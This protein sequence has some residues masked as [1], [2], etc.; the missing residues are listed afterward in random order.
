MRAVRVLAG[1][2][3]LGLA[4]CG[5]GASH[6]ATST[7]TSTAP[8][9]PARNQAVH[10]VVLRHGPR[11]AAVPILMYHLLNA[12]PA[13]TAYPELWVAPATF[14]ATMHKL[15]AAGY[16]GVTLDAVLD[17]WQH[18]IALP[19]RPIVV[20][21]D[22]GYRS[23]ERYA[24]PILRSLGWPGVL[25]LEVKNLSVAGGITHAEVRRLIAA[26]WEIDAHTLTHRDLTTLDAA[27]V[28]HEVGGS[29][30]AL[31]REFGVRVD[32]FAYPAGRYDATAEEAVRTAGFRAAVTTNPGLAHMDGD[33][34]A[35]PRI[36][37][38]GTES[39][40]AVLAAVQA[41]R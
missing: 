35:L 15:A 39:P 9:A 40:A 25:N 12:P 31:R 36:R 10:R 41:A 24:M 18:R 4:G 37:V 5:G 16:H 7:T 32:G 14:R 33:R 8:R 28:R 27:A 29:R 19:R 34:A 26:G 30:A 11:H 3:L 21:F 22:D 2:L 23:E 1:I 17:N 20:S 38:D 13:G 6:A